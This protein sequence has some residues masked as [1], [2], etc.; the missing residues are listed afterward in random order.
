MDITSGWDATHANL[1]DVRSG[2]GA[3]YTTGTDDVRWTAEDWTAHP[4]AV[5]ICQDDGATDDTAD[6]VDTETGAATLEQAIA[7][8]PRARAAWEAGKRPGQREPALYMSASKVAAAAAAVHD[9][10][11][12]DKCYLYQARWGVGAQ[13]AAAEI[14][15]SGGPFRTVAFQYA[16]QG[17]YDNDMWSADWLANVSVAP[18][19]PAP[20]SGDDWTERTLEQLPELKQ[21][22]TGNNV[23][24]LQGLLV[25]RGYHLG[26]TGAHNVGVDGDF[27]VLTDSA[28][29][30]VQQRG[31][32]TADGVVGPQTWPLLLGL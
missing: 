3:G 22:D 7:W 28:V 1:G 5:R 9:A 32:I 31:K 18:Q 17:D 12:D 21:G 8:V 20:P 10:G 24:T 29:K 13:L 14:R 15:D 16:N 11:L 30:D 26:T 27:G 2:Q 25:A 19:P 6:V 23:R 4:G